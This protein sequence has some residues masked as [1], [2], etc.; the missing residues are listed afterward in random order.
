MSSRRLSSRR[1][2]LFEMHQLPASAQA[3]IYV[4]L[5]QCFDCVPSHDD[6]HIII[7]ERR[8]PTEIARCL[9]SGS[10]SAEVTFCAS[11]ACAS[12]ER[13]QIHELSGRD[14]QTAYELFLLPEMAIASHHSR[15]GRRRYLSERRRRPG[16][17]R[18]RSRSVTLP[19]RSRRRALRVD[20]REETL[21]LPVD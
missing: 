8:T 6:R 9:R 11:R 4:E 1:R 13:D 19:S 7:H 21:I 20:H 18:P 2:F 17:S 5:G 14:S 10:S 3:S 15:R 12:L 16:G